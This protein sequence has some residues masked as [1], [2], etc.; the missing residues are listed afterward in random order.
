MKIEYVVRRS[1]GKT[2]AVDKI[3]Q[4]SEH[5]RYVSNRQYFETEEEAKKFKE[6]KEKQK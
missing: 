4:S 1:R 5:Y 3:V 2:W 6:R